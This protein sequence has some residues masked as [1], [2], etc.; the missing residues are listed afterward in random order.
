MHAPPNA[1]AQCSSEYPMRQFNLLTPVELSAALGVSE[2]TLAVWRSRKVGPDFVKL[3]KSVFYREAD[4]KAWIDLN[5]VNTR[6]VGG[7]DVPDEPRPPHA[8]PAGAGAHPRERVRNA[9]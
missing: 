9:R 4:I 2:E 5:V 8:G 7:L 3:G 6:R 1:R